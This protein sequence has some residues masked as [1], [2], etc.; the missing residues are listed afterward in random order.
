MAFID[1]TDPRKREELVREYVQTKRELRLRNE[2]RKEGNLLKEQEIQERYQPIIAATEKSTQEITSAIKKSE[3]NPFEFHSNLRINRDKYF[4][5]YR[6]NN[7]ELKLGNSVIQLDSE[8]NIIISGTVF[9]YSP[10]LWNLIMQNSPDN[11]SENDINKYSQL[12]ELVDLI[13]HP[14]KIGKGNYKITSKYKFLLKLLGIDTSKKVKEPKKRK[15]RKYAKIIDSDDE[16]GEKI[17]TSVI[18]PGDINGLLQK[19][20]LVC[21]ER[22][23]GNIEATTPEIV[24]ILDELLRQKYIDKKEYNVVCQK[25]QC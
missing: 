16:I 10:G 19:L 13:D 2:N 7:G 1:I 24:A 25:L 15:K 8:N 12:I 3:G 22:E 11:Y 6:A 18:L 5:I 9:E 4:S 23:A 21:A 14:R 20:K 17:G